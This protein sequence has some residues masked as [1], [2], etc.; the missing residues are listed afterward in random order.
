MATTSEEHLIRTSIR[1][2]E[3][4]LDPALFWRVH[5]GLIVRVDEIIEANR[6]LRG[7]YTLTLRSRP[8]KLRTSQKYGHLFKGM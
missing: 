1:E 5:R 3:E 7:R 8:E 2:L 4:A 6:D